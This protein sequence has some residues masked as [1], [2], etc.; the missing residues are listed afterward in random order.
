M[1]GSWR[2]GRLAVHPEGDEIGGNMEK[3]LKAINL[4]FIKGSRTKISLVIAGVLGLLAQFGILT[5][6]QVETVIKLALPFGLCGK[7]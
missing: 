7:T 5:Q 6:E 2:I 3:L 4:D 1:D